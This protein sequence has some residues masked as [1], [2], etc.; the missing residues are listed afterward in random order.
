MIK[1]RVLS[2]VR[3]LTLARLIFRNSKIE[4]K[5]IRFVRYDAK[6]S[7]FFSIISA[8]IDLQD[9][10]A[11][12]HGLGIVKITSTPH[13]SFAMSYLNIIGGEKEAYIKYIS[14]YYPGEDLH[15]T[16]S[17]FENTIDYVLNDPDKVTI[18]VSAAKEDK[19]LVIDG[20]HRTD[21]V[22][23][24]GRSSINCAVHF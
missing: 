19:I 16:Q 13:F 12:I 22:Q 21:A 7:K 11:H 10:Y 6:Y 4:K 24:L 20:V 9:L 5:R 2:L 1:T 17:D 18:L 15:K 23:A 14:K 3:R 8:T